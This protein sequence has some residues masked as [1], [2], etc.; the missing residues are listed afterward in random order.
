MIASNSFSVQTPIASYEGVNAFPPIARVVFDN[1]SSHFQVAWG[2]SQTNG[3]VVSTID[4]AKLVSN[5]TVLAK[6]QV[7]EFQDRLRDLSITP[8]TGQDGAFVVWQTQE[9]NES[10]FVSQ[11][12]STAQVVFLKE[13]NFTSGVSKYLTV[14]TDSQNNLYVAW[15]QPSA[16]NPQMPTT[17]TPVTNV[18]YVRMNFDG[19][20]VQVGNGLVKSPV[21]AVTVLTD[22]NVYAV[23]PTGLVAV[24]AQSSSHEN[25]FVLVVG[26]ALMGCGGVAGSA[27][28]EE[29]RYKWLL[30]CSKIRLA[31]SKRPNPRGQE[32]LHL[33]ARRPGLSLRD[34]NRLASLGS[35]GMMSLIRMERAGSIASLRDGLS[36]RF[37]LRSNEGRSINALRTRIMLWILEH[38]GIWEAQVAKD[39]GLSQQIVHYHLKKLRDSKL[40][41]TEI[42]R[43]G[44]RKLYRFA[45]H[46]PEKQ[47]PRMSAKLT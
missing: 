21:I 40:I 33:L 39:L 1:S 31:S 45:H 25:N 36:R 17:P 44:N 2:V 42:D 34:I 10:L 11:I 13:L 3:H 32:I 19:D 29:G 5:G 12:S 37:Y 43:N 9:S 4:Y 6:L 23:S 8:M 28:I 20:I 24:V 18:T 30:F 16:L 41:A 15:S 35:V 47:D 38:P 27:W 7:A 26:I 46:I 22:G 14:S